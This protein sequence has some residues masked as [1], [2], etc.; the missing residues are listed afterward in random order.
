MSILWKIETTMP[1]SYS[2]RL[3]SVKLKTLEWAKKSEKG[4]NFQIEIVLRSEC[5]DTVVIE[6]LWTLF[7]PFACSEQITW[8]ALIPQMMFIAGQFETTTKTK[9][10]KKI[11]GTEEIAFDCYMKSISQDK[12]CTRDS[13]MRQRNIFLDNNWRFGLQNIWQKKDS[14]L[15]LLISVIQRVCLLDRNEWD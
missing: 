12:D 3:N 10:E 13:D 5:I 15:R 14:E 9:H 8:S 1:V 2:I 6:S 7:Y 11:F 4:S